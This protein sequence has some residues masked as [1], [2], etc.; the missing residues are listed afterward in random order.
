[1]TGSVGEQSWRPYRVVDRIE[2][3]AEAFSLLLAPVEGELPYHRTGQYVTIDVEL[4]G[5]DHRPRQYTISSGPNGESFR[6]TIKRVA[7]AVGFPR[8][9]V[10]GWLHEN[11]RPGAVLDVS[12]PRG[13]LV[14]DE[15]DG[16][17]VLISAGIG[18]TPMAAIVE[19]LARRQPDREVWLLHADHSHESHALYETL[20]RHALAMTNVHTQAWYEQDAESAPTL[21][22]AR[23]GFMDLADIDLPA[24]AS[25]FLCGPPRFMQSIH[26]AL[27]AKGITDHNIH[28]EVIGTDG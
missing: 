1:M 14:L 5:G 22:P 20:R 9:Q 28:R 8:G 11:A 16:P 15:S 27:L 6:I 25:V 21:R 12:E 19:D 26:G 2:E 3:S 24:D 4:P 7:G 23:P 13:Q 18:V 17:L 10:S